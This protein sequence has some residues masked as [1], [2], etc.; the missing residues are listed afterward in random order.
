MLKSTCERGKEC[1]QRV[2]ESYLKKGYK[3]WAQR[4]R[5]PFAEIDLLLQKGKKVL[6]IEV[7]SVKNR[8]SYISHT[9]TLR[10]QRAYA[11]LSCRYPQW[12]FLLHLVIV[13]SKNKIHCIQDW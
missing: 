7:K 3:L 8:E 2:L 11:Y 13:D 12:E 6:L 1:E 9:Q 10:L 5:T 4:Y